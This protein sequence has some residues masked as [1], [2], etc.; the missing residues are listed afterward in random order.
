M[1]QFTWV[2]NFVFSTWKCSIEPILCTDS[3]PDLNSKNVI[4]QDENWS[5]DWPLFL[6]LKKT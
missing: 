6:A 3:M 5:P 2:P 4:F 1:V